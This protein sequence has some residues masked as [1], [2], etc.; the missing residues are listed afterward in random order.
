MFPRSGISLR[1]TNFIIS[2]FSKIELGK[3]VDR[4]NLRREELQTLIKQ[5]LKTVKIKDNLERIKKDFGD[6]TLDSN[7]AHIIAGAVKAK[8]RFLLTYNVR[9]FRRQKINAD[10]GIIVLTPAQYLQYLRSLG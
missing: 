10:L 9:H 6:Y 2:N 1:E 7:D 3:V 5:R 4:L 8:A